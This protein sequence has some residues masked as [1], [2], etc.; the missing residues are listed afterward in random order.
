MWLRIGG[1]IERLTILGA[2]LL[3]FIGL[4]AYAVKH[5]E[6]ASAGC[7]SYSFDASMQNQYVSCVQT[8]QY[9]LDQWSY[10]TQNGYYVNQDGYYRDTTTQDVQDFQRWAEAQGDDVTPNGQMTPGSWSA[11]CTESTKLSFKTGNAGCPAVSSQ[12]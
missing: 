5:S 2:F 9:V 12:E 6:A 4:G 1:R 8:L 3:L 10:K 7:V 11:L